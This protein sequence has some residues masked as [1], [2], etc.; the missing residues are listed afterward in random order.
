M[1]GRCAATRD[2][3]QAVQHREEAHHR[4]AAQSER[5]RKAW[6]QQRALAQ[7]HFIQCARPSC[8]AHLRRITAEEEQTERHPRHVRIHQEIHRPRRLIICI[9]CIQH[10][11]IVRRAH[12]CQPNEER[13]V[14]MPVGIDRIAKPMRADTEG[15]AQSCPHQLARAGEELRERLRHHVGSEALQEF[16]HASH[17]EI[18]R[19]HQCA[20]VAAALR[21]IARVAVE[22][23]QRGFI[24]HARVDQLRRRDDDAFLKDVSCIGTDGTRTQSADIGE[25]R[26]AHHECCATAL[27]EYWREEHLIVRMGY[28]AT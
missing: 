27:M 17:P 22:D 16:G 28:R 2:I 7:Q 8:V 13:S 6:P 26:P 24:H 23:L 21:G 4:H 20:C 5:R 25:M 11:P 1:S 15:F 10:K 14:A 9:R 12:Q 18:D 3:H 19:C